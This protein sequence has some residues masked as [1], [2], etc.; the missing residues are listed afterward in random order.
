MYINNWYLLDLYIG[1]EEYQEYL[2]LYFIKLVP[3]DSLKA[4]ASNV[5]VYHWLAQQKP[6]WLPTHPYADKEPLA[7][8]AKSTLCRQWCHRI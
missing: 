4:F 2:Q 8:G 1:T 5:S 7:P 6:R 3:K